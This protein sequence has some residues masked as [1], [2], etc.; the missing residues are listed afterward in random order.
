MQ[1]LFDFLP[2]IVFFVAYKL[3]GMYV[4][5]AA[6]MVAMSIQIAIQWITKRT[7]NKLLLISGALVL[8]FG[9]ITIALRNPLFI[10]WKPTIVNWLFA[11]AFLG[12][13]YIGEKTLIQR[14]MDHA[15]DLPLPMWRR[16]NLMWIGNFAF[17]GGANIYVVYNFSEAAWVNFKLY[18]MLGLTLLMALIQGIWIARQMPEEKQRET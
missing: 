18:G 3:Y 15:I 9:A 14:M 6:I 4:A 1:V 7:V 17:L 10:Q 5:T 16:L 2:V 12:S 8:V 11:V 13:R